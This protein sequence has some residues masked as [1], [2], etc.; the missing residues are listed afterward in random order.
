ML[1]GARTWTMMQSMSSLRSGFCSFGS[2][3]CRM[4]ESV[5]LRS[6]AAGTTRSAERRRPALDRGIKS[7]LARIEAEREC[8][9][10]GAAAVEAGGDAGEQQREGDWPDP[11]EADVLQHQLVLLVGR[12]VHP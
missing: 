9:A 12:Y 3:S 8:R 10:P 4:Q 7:D 2:V 1:W 5:A 6:N 11:V